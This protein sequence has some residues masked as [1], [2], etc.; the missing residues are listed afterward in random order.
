MF[1][2]LSA[3]GILSKLA[4][5]IAL[6]IAMLA[7]WHFKDK[8]DYW[9]SQYEVVTALRKADFEAYKKAQ[10]VARDINTR[11]VLAVEQKWH[12]I[13]LNQQEQINEAR[14][15]YYRHLDD[16][17]K[18]MRSQTLG[19]PSGVAGQGSVPQTA[20]TSETTEGAST[21]SL[22]PVELNDLKICTDNTVK[23]QQWQFFYGQ[24][25]AEQP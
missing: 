8:A 23:A 19:A 14:A 11:E 25:Q 1:E 10:T 16:Y 21:S 6:L 5:P 20:G 12:K 4:L 13:V 2:G 7:A 9:H 24:L 22:I 3:L 15:N 17:A 18:R